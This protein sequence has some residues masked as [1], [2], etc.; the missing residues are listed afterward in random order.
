M[1]LCKRFKTSAGLRVAI[2]GA[3]SSRPARLREFLAASALGHVV[4]PSG[5][6][7]AVLLCTRDGREHAAQA[8]PLLTADIPVWVDKPLATTEADAR[9]MTEV[10]IERGLL[11]ACRSGFRDADAVADAATQL[12]EGPV[13]LEITG[14]AAVD[15]P[16]GG[17]AHY[18]IHH[19]ELACEV[20]EQ[21]R[22]VRP[23]SVAGVTADGDG[24]RARLLAGDVTV[25]LRFRPPAECPGFTLA[26]NGHVHPVTAPPRYLEDQ[27]GDFLT[28]AGEGRGTEDPEALVAPVRLL[29]GILAT[30]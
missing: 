15:S 20:L 23:Q 21:A 16:Y 1:E 24:V 6:V 18:G 11:L 8:L 29:E 12:R 3:D 7:D 2:V 14:P 22:G 30:C 13:P 9:A 10:A 26:V 4:E 17:L 28:G 5:S 25:D 19:V 27:V